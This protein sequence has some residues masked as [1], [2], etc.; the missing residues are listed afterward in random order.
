MLYIYVYKRACNLSL[1]KNFMESIKIQRAQER[2]ENC[3]KTFQD[4]TLT[5][6]NARENVLLDN[7]FN[8]LLK[9]LLTEE[10]E[11]IVKIAKVFFIKCIESKM[12]SAIAFLTLIHQMLPPS[13]SCK[14]KLLPQI[15]RVASLIK[16]I[17]QTTRI[18]L[19]YQLASMDPRTIPFLVDKF[20][21]YPV[22]ENNSDLS[23]Q[24]FNFL[25]GDPDLV[26]DSSM[27][28]EVHYKV[29]RCRILIFIVS[30][31]QI[32]GYAELLMNYLIWNSNRQCMMELENLAPLVDFFSN[33]TEQSITHKELFSIYV[34]VLCNSFLNFGYGILTLKRICTNCNLFITEIHAF[35]LGS[36]LLLH[37]NL[38]SD[39]INV[40][41][42]L[43]AKFS[44]LNNF[45]KICCLHLLPKM[46]LFNNFFENMRLIFD[47]EKEKS[48]NSDKIQKI[49]EEEP[50][51]PP[52][53]EFGMV[54][55]IG[56]VGD[57]FESNLYE[58][59]VDL[60]KIFKNIENFVNIDYVELV[61][62]GH[63]ELLFSL[64][65]FKWASD[66][67]YDRIKI[68]K[69]FLKLLCN[70]ENEDPKVKILRYSWVVDFFE[71]NFN[72]TIYYASL[73]FI[74]EF[75]T[76]TDNILFAFV[77]QKVSNFL[78]QKEN[79]EAQLPAF[80]TLFTL[81]ES[82]QSR[83]SRLNFLVSMCLSFLH[84]VTSCLIYQVDTRAEF[85]ACKLLSKLC[86][87]A[88]I[89]PRD[90]WTQYVQTKIM[91]DNLLFKNSHIRGAVF[92]FASSFRLIPD[93]MT[94]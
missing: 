52:F 12:V 67:S 50:V 15:D 58:E 90:V 33:C 72:D 54:T 63:F 82:S 24:F 41:I 89:D 77:Q 53:T 14:S 78:A 85:I 44:G 1:V 79:L 19:S 45:S 57:K 55:H 36:L 43:L 70:V 23:S 84:N 47:D 83:Q 60:I 75:V 13:S 76:N 56:L 2:A 86:E 8:E 29:S 46:K 32:E 59:Y 91:N 66:P 35:K 61:K 93:G 26:L 38:D 68:I 87:V 16:E 10:N 51:T 4:R 42:N 69:C 94:V 65:A 34:E 31:V 28:D 80:L 39:F 22:I 71:T 64:L 5:K 88:V 49:D 48:N 7:N 18:T 20:L 25:L 81:F 11:S 17:E 62:K 6:R 21:F 92:C 74:S 40:I 9:I 27:F 73:P 30:G 37:T 3:W